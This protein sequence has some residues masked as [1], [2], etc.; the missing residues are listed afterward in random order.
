MTTHNGEH[1]VRPDNVATLLIVRDDETGWAH[2]THDIDPRCRP[3]C[4][5]FIQIDSERALITALAS[6]G[7][8][9]AAAYRVDEFATAYLFGRA[10]PRRDS[11][12]QLTAAGHP[13]ALSSSSRR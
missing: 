7:F 9:L 4:A 2:V 11:P 8:H 6:A 10:A 5:G 3:R 13:V 12:P 1:D